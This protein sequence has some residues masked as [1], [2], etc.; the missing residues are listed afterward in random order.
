MCEILHMDW[1]NHKYQY[2]LKD[3][4]IGSSLE[5]ENLGILVDEK[6]D[7]SHKSGHSP[8]SQFY[9]SP[10]EAWSAG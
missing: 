2:R 6:F 8:E 4:L 7:M 1:G 3:E 10:K 9:H 5:G